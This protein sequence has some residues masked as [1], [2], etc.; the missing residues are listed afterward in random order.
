MKC[1]IQLWFCSLLLVGGTGIKNI[2]A[3]H[4]A[5]HI[6]KALGL[7]TVLR[8]M[9]YH[10]QRRR[11]YLPLDIIVKVCFLWFWTP[12]RRGARGRTYGDPDNWAFSLPRMCG[13]SLQSGALDEDQA[14]IMGT[15]ND[16]DIWMFFP[17]EDVW[18]KLAV[19]SPGRGSVLQKLGLWALGGEVVVCVGRTKRLLGNNGDKDR[20]ER[21][22]GYWALGRRCGSQKRQG[23]ELELQALVAELPL[24][25]KG[26][27]NL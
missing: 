13:L 15:D 23:R 22:T 11:L 4:A 5:S 10:A 26:F 8:A 18:P 20:S 21:F 3:D 9:P 27:F 14:W 25:Y 17:S 6:G 12:K 2:H 16:P 19:R 7:T 24:N 1:I